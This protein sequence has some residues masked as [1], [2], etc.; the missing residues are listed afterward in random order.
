MDAQ[1]YVTKETNIKYIN[2]ASKTDI[3]ETFYK[4][5]GIS[6]Q[7]T[8]GSHLV[9]TRTSV[10]LN[11]SPSFKQYPCLQ[12]QKNKHFLFNFAYLAQFNEYRFQ[13]WDTSWEFKK[14][15]KQFLV[16]FLFL[17]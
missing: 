8:G 2:K 3:F 10:W 1:H 6:S 15:E 13:S 4:G 12:V 9:S 16:L 14:Q 7:W 17:I 5:K 11:A